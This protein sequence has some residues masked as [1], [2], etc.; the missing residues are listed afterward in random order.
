MSFSFPT[1]SWWRALLLP[2]IALPALA[3]DIV[4]TVREDVTLPAIRPLT[5]VC[6]GPAPVGEPGNPDF[7]TI[8][9]QA[10]V[11]QIR[12]HDLYGPLDMPAMYP[13]Q[14]ADPASASSYRFESSDAAFRSIVN[15]GFEP[16]LRIGDS[17]NNVRAVTNR[18]N[19]AK[20]A[21]AVVR[22]Y[23]DASLW[24]PSRV[25]YVEIYNEPDNR[26]FWRGTQIEFF[27]LYAE[28]AR[29]LRAA[30]PNLK[31][32]G[33]GFSPAAALAPAAQSWSRE[34]VAYVKANSVPL[35]FLSWHLYAD[36]PS[37]FATVADYYRNLLDSS[38]FSN[39]ETSVTEYNT[40]E[41][42]RS[43]NPATR[44]GAPGAALMTG[45]WI[46]LQQKGVQT[47]T[48]YRGQDTSIKLPTFYGLWL[49]D[50]KPKPVGLAFP[51]WAEM[52]WYTTRLEVTA[53]GGQVGAVYILGGRNSA[54][55]RAFLIANPTATATSWQ[56]V[57]PG[58]IPAGTVIRRRQISAATSAV[59]SST[60]AELSSEL[61]AW[62]TQMIT[63]EA[64]GTPAARIFS[65]ASAV[66]QQLA[67]DSL[68]SIYAS[69]VDMSAAT[70]VSISDSA[71]AVRAGTVQFASAGQVNVALPAALALG[72]AAFSVL[73]GTRVLA[74]GTIEVVQVAPGVFSLTGDGKGIAAA[75]VVRY[76][77]GGSPR[78]EP[79]AQYD[80]ASR[81]WTAVPVDLSPPGDRVF[82][83]LYGTGVRR[84]GKVSVTVGGADAPLG[85]AGTQG[86][87]A[88]LD[89]MNV[90]LPR[91]LA[92]RGTA[93]IVVTAD[94]KAANSVEVALK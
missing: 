5:G 60:L 58:G 81:R 89:Q 42:E 76:P 35:D 62:G 80:A 48:F 55:S 70:S 34:F 79:I 90:E 67:P 49:A 16:Y 17:Y 59:Q 27:Q 26:Q 47:A 23:T 64:A 86:E 52:T 11:T 75:N 15:G 9:Q 71:G 46:V 18:S 12:T 31:I 84:A 88:G 40:E 24:G 65:A 36:R 41:V 25:R 1:R 4:F 14:N 66:E 56:I 33:P 85:F 38:G 8:Y 54:G 69:G 13:D 61:P 63:F 72:R 91:S 22:R 50:G 19:W 68:A 21:V 6:G 77:Q 94:G 83:F 2:L 29:A 10:G 73:A 32:G 57:L 39:V 78:V 45:A 20:A 82:L 7:T 87:F 43:N 28:T 37:D 74:A 53:S 44:T 93:P 51:L 30:F 92:G 3:A